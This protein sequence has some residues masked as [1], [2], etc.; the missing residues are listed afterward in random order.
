M[1]RVI[2]SATGT[3]VDDPLAWRSPAGAPLDLADLPPFDAGAI[4]IGEFSLWRYAA[5]LPVTRRFS[6]G[7][8]MTPLVATSIDG[9]PFHAK[10]EYLNP[11]GSYKDRGTA[12]VLNHLAAH[13][14]TH[15]IE[16]SSGNAGASVAA[17]SQIAGIHASIYVP[18]SAAAAK[19]ALIRAFGGDLVE[20]PGPQ[21]AKT[22]ACLEAATHTPYASH[23]WSPYFGLG[24]MTAAWEVWEGLGQR[25]PDAVAMPVGHGGLFLGFARGFRALYDAGLIARLPRMIAVQSAACDPIVRALEAGADDPVPVEARP[26]LADGIIVDVPVRGREVLA[27][28]RATDGLALRVEDDAIARAHHSL[29]RRSLLVEPTSAATIAA[30]PAIR[31]SIGTDATLVVALTGSGLKTLGTA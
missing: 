19:K 3:P 28:I 11:T 9:L 21:Y 8:G 31:K 27:A 2:C 25:A 22:A 20:V 29:W 14:V 4:D 6:L 17:Y 12:L 16:D 1:T 15:V 13:G 30:L 18:T 23:A 26:T 10:L 24:Q 7:E 5:M